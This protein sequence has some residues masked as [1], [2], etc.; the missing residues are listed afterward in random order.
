MKA[1]R[2]ALVDLATRHGVTDLR[3][4]GSIAWK[5]W[6]ADILLMEDG[7]QVVLSVWGNLVWAEAGLKLLGERPWPPQGRFGAG[8]CGS[9]LWY[10]CR[11]GS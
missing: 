3:I 1:N 4:F 6:G 2:Q 5:V 10:G 8:T 9:S 11:T 7:G